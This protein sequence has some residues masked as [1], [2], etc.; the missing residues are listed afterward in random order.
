MRVRVLTNNDRSRNLVIEIQS[1]RIDLLWFW[2]VWVG[3]VQLWSVWI[4]FWIDNFGVSF[5]F[6]FVGVIHVEILQAK[7]QLPILLFLL[8][9]HFFGFHDDIDTENEDRHQ[10]KNR[11]I[12]GGRIG[13]D[14]DSE[15]TPDQIQWQTEQAKLEI[16]RLELYQ[17]IISACFFSCACSKRKLC[18]PAPAICSRIWKWGWHLSSWIGEWG[19]SPGRQ[20]QTKTPR[21]CWSEHWPK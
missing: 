7:I 10:H 16:W 8:F 3:L 9:W 19:Q 12:K 14:Q 11:N 4:S 6:I 18:S 13:A 5:G 17:H 20:F 15:K 21:C 1:L 2:L